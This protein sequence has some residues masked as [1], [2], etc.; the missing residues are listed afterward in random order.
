[1]VMGIELMRRKL[2]TRV[3]HY[4]LPRCEA[5]ACTNKDAWAGSP[6]DTRLPRSYFSGAVGVFSDDTRALSACAGTGGAW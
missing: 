6:P 1:M 4:P 3:Y 2:S 5:E